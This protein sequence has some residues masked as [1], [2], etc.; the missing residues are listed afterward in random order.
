MK[1]NNY[2]YRLLNKSTRQRTYWRVFSIVLSMTFGLEF[3]NIVYY[4][5]LN[6]SNI[7]FTTADGGPVYRVSKIIYLSL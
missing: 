1:C 6:L 7:Y 4:I 5:L 3:I 2:Y